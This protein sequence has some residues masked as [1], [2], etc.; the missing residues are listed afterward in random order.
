MSRSAALL[1]CL[2]AMLVGGCG[3]GQQARTIGPLRPTDA[4]FHAP[5]CGGDAP[6]APLPGSFAISSSGAVAVAAHT[7]AAAAVVLPDGTRSPV[8]SIR[9]DRGHDTDNADVAVAQTLT[10]VWYLVRYFDVHPTAG[11][12]TSGARLVSVAADG[13]V[14]SSVDVA[15]GVHDTVTAILPTGG[16]A[17][18]LATVHDRSHDVEVST[19]GARRFRARLGAHGVITRMALLDH[20]RIVALR[21]GQLIS[22]AANGAVADFARSAVGARQILDIAPLGRGALAA[23][24]YDPDRRQVAIIRLT[25]RGALGSPP[26]QLGQAESA[27][28][29][30]AFIGATAG[31]LIIGWT[32]GS[33]VQLRRYQ[34]AQRTADE[35]ARMHL[36]GDALLAVAGRAQVGCVYSQIPTAGAL[37]KQ[38][39]AWQL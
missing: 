33:E 16:G 34:L 7:C 4:T 22:I 1:T 36:K 29:P 38:C 8:T 31:A 24:T 37:A 21:G 23:L 17:V 6:A 12:S 3:G 2:A 9:I 26:L 32:S 14:L 25:A 5:L 39:A 18:V 27:P 11:S 30:R 28:A 13:R 15:R 20:R 35:H 19:L 10:Q